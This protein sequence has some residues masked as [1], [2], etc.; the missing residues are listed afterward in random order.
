MDDK[1]IVDWRDRS[2]LR[3]CATLPL[4][5]D[6]DDVFSF[7]GVQRE[8]FEEG[9]LAVHNLELEDNGLTRFDDN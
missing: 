5:V 4:E 9:D 3:S 6:S 2:K 7:F 8:D 1:N